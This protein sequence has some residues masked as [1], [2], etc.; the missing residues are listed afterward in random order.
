MDGSKHITDSKVQ[1]S[2]S[3]SKGD[4]FNLPLSPDDHINRS[5]YPSAMSS[6][7]SS[8]SPGRDRSASKSSDTWSPRGEKTTPRGSIVQGM[9]SKFQQDNGASSTSPQPL[10]QRTQRSTGSLQQIETSPMARRGSAT[11]NALSPVNSALD[12]QLRTPRISQ[13]DS[14]EEGL[15][16]HRGNKDYER[17]PLSQTSNSYLG[18][19]AHQSAQGVSNADATKPSTSLSQ[20][21]GR[22]VSP[23]ELFPSLGAL[24]AAGLLARSKA[25]VE[26]SLPDL[27]LHTLTPVEQTPKPSFADGILPE[28]LAESADAQNADSKGSKNSKSKLAMGWK[29]L[30][31]SIRPNSNSSSSSLNASSI[32]AASSSKRDAEGSQQTMS[33]VSNERISLLTDNTAVPER[34]AVSDVASQRSVHPPLG[35]DFGPDFSLT[36]EGLGSAFGSNDFQSSFAT[37]LPS[38]SPTAMP[39]SSSKNDPSTKDPLVAPKTVVTTPSIVTTAPEEKMAFEVDIAYVNI[40][41]FSTPGDMAQVN[42]V[43]TVKQQKQVQQPEQLQQQLDQQQGQMARLSSPKAAHTPEQ[44]AITVDNVLGKSEPSVATVKPM[45]GA[46]K[47]DIIP[48]PNRAK[49]DVAAPAAGEV[50]E[51]QTPKVSD[52]TK[53]SHPQGSSQIKDSVADRHTNNISALTPPKE[54]VQNKQMEISKHS[55]TVSKEPV[56]IVESSLRVSLPIPPR[57]TRQRIDQTML[58]SPLSPLDVPEKSIDSEISVESHEV[59]ISA[60]VVTPSDISSED[61]PTP[62]NEHEEDPMPALKHRTKPRRLNSSD[63]QRWRLSVE[64]VPR[65]YGTICHKTGRREVPSD[66]RSPQPSDLIAEEDE[67]QKES[68]AQ[69]DDRCDNAFK[70][71]LAQSVQLASAMFGNGKR[72]PLSLYYVSEELRERDLTRDV[73]ELFPLSWQEADPELEKLLTAFDN[74]PFGQGYDLS[75]TKNCSHSVQAG[76]DL[77]SVQAGIS[78]R[79]LTC[80]ILRFLKELPDPLLPQDLIDSLSRIMEL[81]CADEV[82]GKAA[83]ALIHALPD[84][85]VHLLQFLIEFVELALFR[86]IHEEIQQSRE[87]LAQILESAQHQERSPCDQPDAIEARERDLTSFISEKQQQL[88]DLK[89]RTVHLLAQVICGLTM[90]AGSAGPMSSVATQVVEFFV[91]QRHNILGPATFSLPSDQEHDET[92]QH[93]NNHPEST[94]STAVL[95]EEDDRG[96]HSDSMVTKVAKSAK[97]NQKRILRSLHLRLAPHGDDTVWELDERGNFVCRNQSEKV[98]ADELEAVRSVNNNLATLRA[99]HEQMRQMHQLSNKHQRRNSNATVHSIVADAHSVADVE[100]EDRV[101]A[102]ERTNQGLADALNGRQEA[103]PKARNQSKTSMLQRFGFRDILQ[104]PLERK[105][106]DK[107]LKAVEKEILQS[108]TVSRHLVSSL[109]GMYPSTTHT[110]IPLGILPSARKQIQL[111]AAMAAAS[112]AAANHLTKSIPPPPEHV[113]ANSEDNKDPRHR[114]SIEKTWKPQEPIVIPPDHQEGNT[115]CPCT[116]CRYV[117]KPSRIALPTREENEAAELKADCEAKEQHVTELLKTVHDLQNQVNVLNAKLLFLHDHHTTRPMRRRALSRRQASLQIPMQQLPQQQQQHQ[118]STGSTES[119][120]ERRFRQLQ[121]N[122]RRGSVNSQK[123]STSDLHA[124]GDPYS[125]QSSDVTMHRGGTHGSA[126]NLPTPQSLITSPGFAT[127]SSLLRAFPDGV[128]LANNVSTNPTQ[129]SHASTSNITTTSKDQALRHHRSLPLLSNPHALPSLSMPGTDM[130]V[131]EFVLD[132]DDTMSHLDLD[133]D[134]Y[135]PH[136]SLTTLTDNRSQPHLQSSS[137]SSSTGVTG[138]PITPSTRSSTV[139]SFGNHSYAPYASTS[140]TPFRVGSELELVLRDMEEAEEADV[141]VRE[142]EDQVDEYYY[143]DAYKTMDQQ[144]Y[145]RP[146]LPVPQAPPPMSSEQYKRHQRMSLPIQNLMSRR[147]ANTFKWKS[148]RAALA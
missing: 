127:P 44:P 128:P 68:D 141:Y 58:P 77:E 30:R 9:I 148:S 86:P 20:S 103:P 130:D 91:R 64:G 104:E 17:S 10:R 145:R 78:S 107:E 16:A 147:L 59:H 26:G 7:S 57:A 28:D 2:A 136:H 131:P 38:P 98:L 120:D 49:D 52:M 111:N 143:A 92:N 24:D 65:V 90:D 132:E 125:P 37:E 84:D 105:Q 81:Q 112:F 117:A 101:A 135:F 69:A 124:P 48:P 27:H 31:K 51:Q 88:D 76:G 18:A 4:S 22:D 55:Q 12:F 19:P 60:S 123:S 79:Q 114:P 95:V 71:P 63:K 87:T 109:S 8:P 11:Q 42:T 119:M 41:S 32:S 13:K 73:T 129:H 15:T 3:H 29:K 83:S 72:I 138:R 80:V 102:I 5:R 35:S 6:H 118:I 74:R 134:H 85:S 121:Q 14:S 23:L 94:Q 75:E 33:C 106:E 113:Y 54:P 110:P 34:K 96:Y 1:A 89:E 139:V 116:Y 144:L 50:I 115:A 21:K 66:E 46:L 108:E 140:S 53:E 100:E 122:L 70:V 137:A 43:P 39:P 126:P 67:S 146:V 36:F 61:S 62:E 40:E 93:A 47:K 97:R 99:I 142:G 133:Q 82:K 45:G 25:D 56:S